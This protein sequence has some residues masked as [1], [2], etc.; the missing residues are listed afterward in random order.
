MYFVFSKLKLSKLFDFP[1]H[2]NA[3]YEINEIVDFDNIKSVPVQS[4]LLHQY[5]YGFLYAV[6]HFLLKHLVYKSVKVKI[7]KITYR[8]N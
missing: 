3:L 6:G 4:V 1:I 7:V 8:H 5:P 2:W